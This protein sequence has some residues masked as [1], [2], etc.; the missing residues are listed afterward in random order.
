MLSVSNQPVK[1]EPIKTCNEFDDF[2]G[3]KYD[4]KT[5]LNRNYS[6]NDVPLEFRNKL[7]P[8]QKDGVKFA[9][10]SFGRCLI[11]DEMGLGKTI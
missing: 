7:F 10:K 4:Y 3:V 5:D 9:L 8:F 2:T 6:I 1:N 11:G